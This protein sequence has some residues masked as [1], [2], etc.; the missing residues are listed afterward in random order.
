VSDQDKESKTEEPTGKRISDAL[1]KGNVPVSREAVML[2]S[3]LGMLISAW[4][5]LPDMAKE[6]QVLLERFIDD[7]SDFRIESS[8]DALNLLRAVLLETT[9]AV[10]P[11][12][13]VLFALGLIATLL[14]NPPQLAVARIEPKLSNISLKKGWDRIFGMRNVVEFGK[15]LFKLIAV[16]VLGYFLFRNSQ[17][18][19]VNSLYTEVVLVPQVVLSLVIKFLSVLAVALVVLVGADIAWTK[20]KWVRDLRMTKQEVKDEHKQMEGD[21]HV[22]GRFKSLQRD[23][24]RRRMIES[25]PKATLVIANPTH[26]AVALRYVKSESAAPVV[27]AK[28][29]DLIALKIREIAEKNDIPVIEDVALARSLYKA[30]EVDRA[31]PPEFYKAVA[32]LIIYLTK[33]GR[34][35]RQAAQGT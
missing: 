1:E 11:V 22:K 15:S 27:V 23:R 8:G 32:E 31:I 21:P 5:L 20:F 17:A 9:W 28:G 24:A 35:V 30:V 12:L 10:L 19:V 18:E 14:Q 7:P 26:F 3:V 13:L 4:L 2:G 29:Q 16:S 25:V 33:Q 6:V 34:A